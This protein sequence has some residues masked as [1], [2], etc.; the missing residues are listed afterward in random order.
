MDLK[1]LLDDDTGVSPVIGVILMVAI[2]VILAAVI[3]TFVMN[4]G[5]SES[6]PANA[7]WDWSE[8]KAT[9]GGD[10]DI[11]SQLTHEGGGAAAVDEYKLKIDVAGSS[12]T[13]QFTDVD[14]YS[15][16]SEMSA[17]DTVKVFNASGSTTIAD[18]DL[19]ASYVHLD[20]GVVTDINEIQL[21]WE[22]PEGDQTQIIDTY[23]P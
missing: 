2:T 1:S 12:E 7:N 6:T 20:S 16:G 4:M 9:S 22:D 19:P 5:P 15:S 8:E 10:V 18:A 11:Y 3:A 17:S 14:G 23:E 21:I 13:I